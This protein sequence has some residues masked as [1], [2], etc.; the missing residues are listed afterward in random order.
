MNLEKSV[1]LPQTRAVA[2][3]SVHC[4]PLMDGWIELAAGVDHCFLLMDSWIKLAELYPT[5]YQR[6][7]TNVVLDLERYNSAATETSTFTPQTDGVPLA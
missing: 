6:P 2:R 5:I 1:A 7:Q 3:E 4:F